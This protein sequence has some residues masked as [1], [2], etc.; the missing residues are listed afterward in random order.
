MSATPLAPVYLLSGTDRGKI[1]RALERLR[2]RYSSEAIE[3]F[4][5]SQHEPDAIAGAC[6]QQGLFVEERLIVVEGIDAW[7]KPRRAGRLDH[8]VGRF[9]VAMHQPGRMR[10]RHGFGNLPLMVFIERGHAVGLLSV[11]IVVV[12]A[13][14]ASSASDIF[15]H[16]PPL[17]EMPANRTTIAA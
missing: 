2:D 14:G 15:R 4:D 16:N 8:D 12:P 3:V 6:S 13:F 10:F 17:E 11:L 9:Q 1:R 5:A 7:V